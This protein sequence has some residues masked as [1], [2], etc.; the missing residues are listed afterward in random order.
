M[1]GR[2]VLSSPAFRCAL[3]S[4]PRSEFVMK[5]TRWW[6]VVLGLAAFSASALEQRPRPQSGA[7]AETSRVIV[8]FRDPPAGAF[9]LSGVPRT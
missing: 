9:A 7:D 3:C 4:E 1:P 6:V 2:E 8:K 5:L